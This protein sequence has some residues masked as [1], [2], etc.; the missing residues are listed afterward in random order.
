MTLPMLEALQTPVAAVQLSLLQNGSKLVLGKSHVPTDAFLTLQARITNKTC[1]VLTTQEN[2]SAILMFVLVVSGLV[3]SLDVDFVPADF[4]LY[5]GT[6]SDIS[7]GLLEA[8]A[9][10]TIDIPVLFLGGGQ[11][12]I[13]A[14]ANAFNEDGKGSGSGRGV[15][16]VTARGP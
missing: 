11:F 15:L 9:S 1:N 14:T 7:I 8:G 5:D 12:E 13:T 3:F 16:A 2:T 6:A 10:Q 4:I